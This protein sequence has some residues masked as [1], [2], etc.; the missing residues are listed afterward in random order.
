[1]VTQIVA[2]PRCQRYHRPPID[3]QLNQHDRP[4][5]LPPTARRRQFGYRSVARE[6]DCGVNPALPSVKKRKDGFPAI[7][8]VRLSLSEPLPAA[9]RCHPQSLRHLIWINAHAIDV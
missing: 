7:E 2:R 3:T 1:M 9:V 4:R 5:R 6:A 8:T